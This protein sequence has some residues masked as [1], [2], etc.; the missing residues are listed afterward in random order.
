MYTKKVK[1]IGGEYMVH[2]TDLQPRSW[3]EAGHRPSQSAEADGT[4]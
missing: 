3:C 1:E 2:G 4:G